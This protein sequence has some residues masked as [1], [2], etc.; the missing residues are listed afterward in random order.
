MF[1]CII[2][3][4][5]YLLYLVVIIAP[6]Y[7]QYKLHKLTGGKLINFV[8]KCN[9]WFVDRMFRFSRKNILKNWIKLSFIKSIWW[10]KFK[11]IFSEQHYN[12]ASF[13]FIHKN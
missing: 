5:S 8:T 1:I 13:N 11:R 12:V 10:D 4:C 2:I 6:C 7:F 9:I 3:L